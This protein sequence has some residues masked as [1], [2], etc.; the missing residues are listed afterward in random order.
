[1][2]NIGNSN[3][4]PNICE[5]HKSIPLIRLISICMPYLEARLDYIY[6]WGPSFHPPQCSPMHKDP[7][8]EKKKHHKLAMASSKKS[9][10][11]ATASPIVVVV[12]L[13]LLTTLLTTMA[14]AQ[15]YSAMP[16]GVVGDLLPRRRVPPSG[17]SHPPPMVAMPPSWKIPPVG[18]RK[19]PFTMAMT[20]N[21]VGDLLPRGPS[22]SPGRPLPPCCGK[23]TKPPSME[24]MIDHGKHALDVNEKLV[25]NGGTNT[26]G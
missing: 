1:M 5:G 25:A 23:P 11:S 26:Q 8:K 16:P 18:H 10:A 9:I 22:P 2:I 12:A 7:Y 13:T 20:P 19:P 15:P 21:V 4:K 24:E 14:D 17:P 6:T 3:C